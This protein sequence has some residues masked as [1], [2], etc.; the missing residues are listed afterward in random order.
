MPIEIIG[1]PTVRETDGLAMSSRN[2][3]LSEN[4]RR[5]AA[6]LFRALNA[7]SEAL[8]AGE[9]STSR[10]HDRMIDVVGGEPLI[11]LDYAEV[12]DAGSMLPVNE[13]AAPAVAL[14]AARVGSTRLIDNLILDPGEH[15][16]RPL[17]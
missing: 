13:V 11:H 8:A 9:R 4:D 12:V 5:T 7:A 14:I 17:S 10:L 2:V 16:N 6:V 3:Y 1:V 15:D